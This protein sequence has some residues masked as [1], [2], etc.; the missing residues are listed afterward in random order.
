MLWSEIAIRQRQMAF[1][2]Q[3]NFSGSGNAIRRMSLGQVWPN[4]DSPIDVSLAKQALGL[5]E[6]SPIEY[7]L[8]D[9]TRAPT[10]EATFLSRKTNFLD[11]ISLALLLLEK[12]TAFDSIK[13]KTSE[14]MNTQLQLR[15]KQQYSIQTKIPKNGSIYIREYIYSNSN[16]TPNIK[17]LLVREFLHSII[18]FPSKKMRRFSKIMKGKL[19]K[20]G[21]LF[22]KN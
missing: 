21:W 1:H 14:T 20:E 12:Y 6:A 17:A 11:L 7:V 8:E 18:E 22:H 3:P 2:L 4:F 9:S 19:A 13:L 15:R 16:S 5:K 10:L